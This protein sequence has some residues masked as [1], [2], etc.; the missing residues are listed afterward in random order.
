[1]TPLPRT[2]GL[3]INYLSHSHWYL[4]AKKSFQSCFLPKVTSY[5]Y[6]SHSCESK[7]LSSLMYYLCL[8]IIIANIYESFYHVLDT[9][10]SILH[11]LSKLTVPMIL[12]SCCYYQKSTDGESEKWSLNNV[13]VIVKLR[14]SYCQIWPGG[15]Q[16]QIYIYS[17]P[18]I[19]Q[20][21]SSF[22]I[23]SFSVVID[24]T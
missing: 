13:F 11:W 8:C 24:I 19:V 1:M 6:S 14:N 16:P 15:G 3:L 22:I 17:L 7:V 4:Y 21:Q 12:F 5:L 18:K 20:F 10:L 9:V 2:S 23:F